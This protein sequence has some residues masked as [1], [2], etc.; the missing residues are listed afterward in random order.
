MLRGD[1]FATSQ[2][3]G[4]KPL[5]HTCNVFFI[6]TVFFLFFCDINS[7]NLSFLGVKTNTYCCVSGDGSIN[8]NISY[9]WTMKLRLWSQPFLMEYYAIDAV[10]SPSGSLNTHRAILN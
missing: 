3:S 5:Q 4:M 8:L 9:D 6:L 2:L 7:L 10:S 1:E